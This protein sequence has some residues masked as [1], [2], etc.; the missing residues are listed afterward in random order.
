MGGLF[1]P[2]AT[3]IGMMKT[4]CDAHVD[5]ASYV[6]I[7]KSLQ[8]QDIWMFK[9]GNPNGGVVF[10]DACIHGWEDIG[11][12]VQYHYLN[13]LLNSG[14]ASA[15]AI[16]A[17]N[18][19]LLVPYVNMDSTER[20]NNNLA[21]CPRYGV[22]LNRNFVRGWSSLACGNTTDYGCS[23][24]ASAG[25]E[26]E[27]QVMRSAF[28]TYKPQYYLN[29]HYGGG[30]SLTSYD[31]TPQATAIFN[32]IAQI[33]S[34]RGVTPYST[35]QAGTGNGFAVDDAASF[36]A[37]AFLIECASETEP[38]DV[39]GSCYSHTSHTLA[40]VETYFF[41]KILPIFM[42]MSEACTI[43]TTKKYV[44]AHWQDGDVNP[45]KTV[46]L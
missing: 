20:G 31:N 15:Q 26:P 7:G 5:K 45:I 42:A 4:L 30:P 29:M 6:S 9:I 21:Y 3:L 25:S 46:A 1:Y 33:S 12:V 19:T 11:S 37:N 16:L 17:G 22:D 32:R 24:G 39:G 36:G 13:W 18:L 43:I 34:Q 40:Q 14:E 8:G 27:T 23:H 10:F 2:K 41:P 38:L 28:D 44:F 35:S